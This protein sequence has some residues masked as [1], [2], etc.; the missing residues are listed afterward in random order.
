MNQMAFAH[1]HVDAGERTLR[2]RLADAASV[3]RFIEA[4]KATLTIVSSRTGA[5][6]TFKFVRPEEE[7]HKERCIWV[8]LL[9][10][11]DNES[12][13]A[14]IGTMWPADFS[15][16][17]R[18]RASKVGEDAASYKALS[19]ILR[20]VYVDDSR[21]DQ[22]E[23]WHEGRCGRCGRKLTVPSSIASGFGPDCSEQMG[24]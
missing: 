3:R 18:S 11:P 16:V 15:T 17:K 19:W 1:I 9:N 14:F 10:G 2:G 20:A 24:L 8:R 5:R 6:F 12:N 4:G 21:L 7:P 13:Y 22:A 23:I